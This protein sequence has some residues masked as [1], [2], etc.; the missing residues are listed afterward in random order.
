MKQ[1]FARVWRRGSAFRSGLA[2]RLG[3]SLGFGDPG[4]SLVR[5][6]RC[7]SDFRSSLAKRSPFF[8][9]V[10]HRESGFRSSLS[11]RIGFS[12]GFGAANLVFVWHD[13][14]LVLCFSFGLGVVSRLFVRIWRRE[15]VCRSGFGVVSQLFI[16]A[17][18]V[19][20]VCRSDLASRIGSS[21]CL[22]S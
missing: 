2:L 19:E 3:F 14:V 11:S 16:R 17:W 13:T 15:S 5:I 9:W 18:R 7:Q 12:L 8:A 6:W 4:W 21:L 1:S 10:W 20:S 22:A